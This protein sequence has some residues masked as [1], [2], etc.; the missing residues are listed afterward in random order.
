MKNQI[1]NLSFDNLALYD[2]VEKISK[3][4]NETEIKN[5]LNDL[6]FAEIKKLKEI[7]GRVS[8]LRHIAT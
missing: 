7:V 2:A 3:T 8:K 1:E 4:S 6:G 5:I